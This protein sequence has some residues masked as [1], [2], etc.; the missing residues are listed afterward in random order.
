MHQFKL[1]Y[2]THKDNCN[3]NMNI[4]SSKVVDHHKM[5]KQKKTN[6]QT[7]KKKKLTYTEK[8]SFEKRL[9]LYSDINI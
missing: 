4:F 9:E 6:K 1:M 7:K 2:E 3:D 5:K 8:R